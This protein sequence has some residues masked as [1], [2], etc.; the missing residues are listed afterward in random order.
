MSFYEYGFICGYRASARADFGDLA[1][2]QAD[3]D[4]GYAA[5]KQGLLLDIHHHQQLNAKELK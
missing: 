1:L 4:R 3:Y 2:A 5:G